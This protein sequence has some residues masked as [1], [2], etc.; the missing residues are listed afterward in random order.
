MSLGYWEMSYDIAT[1]LPDGYNNGFFEVFF[2]LLNYS[3]VTQNDDLKIFLKM[4][5]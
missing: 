1:S 2:W 5:F 4:T 3:S